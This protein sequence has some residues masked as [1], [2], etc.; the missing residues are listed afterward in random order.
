MKIIIE[1]SDNILVGLENYSK[2]GAADRKAFDS[3]LSRDSEY[4][5]DV[6]ALPILNDKHTLCKSVHD[7]CVYVAIMR[8]KLTGRDKNA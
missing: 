2:R 7:P 3:T 6:G 5:L 8:L 4:C 1:N